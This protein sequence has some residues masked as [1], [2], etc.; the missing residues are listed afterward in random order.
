MRS[1]IAANSYP[2][3]NARQ[4]GVPVM[5]KTNP[6]D[7]IR[8]TFWQSLMPARAMSASAWQLLKSYPLYFALLMMAAYAVWEARTPV[9]MIAPF[10]LP[11]SDLPFTGDIVADAVQD[12]LKSIR[13]EID[14]EKQDA[15]L[16]S[17]DTGLPDLRNIL[18]P[19]FWRVQAPP[20]FTVEI[21]GVSYERLLSILRALMHTETL[22]SGDVIVTGSQFSLMARASDAGPWESASRPISAEGLKQASRDLAEQIVAAEDP[23]LAGVALLKDGQFE[24]G[25][26]E[27]S[28]AHSL[29]PTDARLKLN[30]CMGFAVNRRYPEAIDCYK[31]VLASRSSPE[32]REY[33][34]RAYYLNGDRKLAT[35]L[36]QELSDK[37]GYRDA[38]LGLG[39]ALDD[40]G[41]HSG[42]LSVYDKYLATEPQDRNRAIAHVKRSLALS[43]M[44]RHDEALNEYQEALKYAPRD[45]LILVHQGLELA[46]SKDLD[47]G[48]AEIQSAVDANKKSD[49]LPFALLQLGALLQRKG[50]WRGAIDEYQMAAQLRP[51]YVEAHLKLARALVHEGKRAQAFDEYDKVARLS[52]S[53]LER[54]Y[55]RMFANQWL[56]NELRNLGNYTGAA[57]VYQAAV[58]VKPDDSAAHCQLALIFAR[59]GHLSQAVREYGAALVPAKLQELNDSECLV[60]VDHLLTEALVSRRPGHAREAIAELR[61]IKQRNMLNMQSTMA[62]NA[63]PPSTDNAKIIEQAVLRTGQ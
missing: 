3:E 40:T 56:A 26:A 52:P 53:D 8:E 35:D 45:V 14:E 29:N 49:F 58:Q 46:E 5:P 23:T 61:K 6:T 44:H 42:A 59:Q 25:L 2:H 36:Y 10:Q 33:L 22:V 39:E 20:R 13:N 28:R 63:L 32:V 50:D 43:H 51:T 15:A 48:I 55:S 31:Q 41:D 54:G 7:R 17:S 16:R 37:E 57:A 9:T 47:S 4:Q 27:L 38:L 60:I 1:S 21:K 12:G 62:Q 34:A 18:I 19:K 30:L 11:K 24:Q